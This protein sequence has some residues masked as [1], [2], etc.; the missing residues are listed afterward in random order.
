MLNQAPNE[1][2]IEQLVEHVRTGPRCQIK[3]SWQPARPVGFFSLGARLRLAW[4]VF[5]GEADAL[6]WSGQ[7]PEAY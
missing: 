7:D 3:R 2:T 4:M 5:T 6:R 1:W